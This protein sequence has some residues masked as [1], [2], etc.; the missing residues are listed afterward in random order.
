MEAIRAI[1]AEHIVVST[2]GGQMQNPPWYE[3]M[4]PNADKAK[5]MIQKGARFLHYSNEQAILMERYRS[6]TESV[7]GNL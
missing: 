1:G 3:T 6:F 5:E 2:D 7:C 4:C